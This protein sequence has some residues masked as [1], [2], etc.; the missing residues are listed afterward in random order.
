[1]LPFESLV[2]R[3]NINIY[4]ILKVL[5]SIILF[6]SEKRLIE[7]LSSICTC[8]KFIK[9]NKKQKTKNVYFRFE[10]MYLLSEMIKIIG[11]I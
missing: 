9:K 11:S 10:N 5:A 2:F 7:P 3:N 8:M 6:I 4:Q 1:M